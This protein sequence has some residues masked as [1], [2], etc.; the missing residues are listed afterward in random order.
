MVDSLS[1]LSSSM[2][3]VM[4]VALRSSLN[5]SALR[6]NCYTAAGTFIQVKVN[7]SQGTPAAVCTFVLCFSVWTTALCIRRAHVHPR[8][9]ESECVPRGGIALIIPSDIFLCALASGAVREA[10]A[11][12]SRRTNPKARR[13]G[14]CGRAAGRQGTIMP[15]P[16]RPGAFAI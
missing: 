15:Y 2:R 6:S 10:W 3:C 8:R 1:H 16:K 12:Y 5:D 11:A 7:S 9:S 13:S 14:G 4:E